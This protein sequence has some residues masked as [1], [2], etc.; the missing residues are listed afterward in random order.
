[1]TVVVTGASGHIGNNLVR[2]LLEQSGQP[3]QADQPVQPGLPAQKAETQRR[4]VRVLVYGPDSRGLSGLDVEEVRGDVRD[5]ASLRR[6]F[7]GA[8]IV[9]HL[10]A[11]ISICEED[12]KYVESVNAEGT[13]NVVAACQR[14]GVRRL[15]HFSSVHA[16]WG[17]PIDRP[18]DEN[19][20]LADRPDALPYDRSKARGEKAV[21][22]GVQNGLDAVIVNPGAVLGP[23]DFR[24]SAQGELL[25]DLCR[26]RLP[27]LIEGGYNWCDV[28]DVVKGA[29]AAE[30]RGRRGERYLLTG[31]PLSFKDIAKLVEKASGARAPRLVTPLWLARLAAPAHMT[32]SKLLGKRQLLTNH[33]VQIVG[34]NCQFV[35]DKAR[36]ELGYTPRPIAETITDSIA[37]YRSAGY[38]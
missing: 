15:V 16:L 38:L 6:A 19:Q 18:I 28:R 27:A 35:L 34:S 23:N 31:H 11:H 30:K 32:V 24:P 22:A 25:I 3:G 36:R 2:A 9:Y 21:L 29:L 17:H 7:S 5:P 26:G 12:D 10:A 13:K 20:E 8:E 14:E 33:S 1:M 4:K 37:W